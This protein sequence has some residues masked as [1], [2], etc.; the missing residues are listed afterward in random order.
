[1]E[2][3]GPQL[4][5]TQWFRGGPAGDAVTGFEHADVTA[6][7]RAHCL[8]SAG[9]DEVVKDGNDPTSGC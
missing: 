5:E 3:A 6:V 4:H 7:H 9:N 1:M 8:A 2:V